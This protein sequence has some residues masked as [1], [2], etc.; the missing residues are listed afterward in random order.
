ME[1]T[2]MTF[3]MNGGQFNYAKDNATINATQNNGVNTSELD[4]IIKSITENLSALKK[5]DAESIIDAVE[6]V[7]E[8]MAKPEPKVSR[9]RSCVTLLAPMLTITNGIPT[10]ASNLHRLVDYITPFIK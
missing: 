6:M 8:E 7:R 9:L 10:L 4:S 2:N 1:D 3:N 5:E